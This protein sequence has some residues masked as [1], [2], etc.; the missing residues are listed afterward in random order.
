MKKLQGYGMMRLW[1]HV[2]LDVWYSST[3]FRG[4]NHINSP[5]KILRCFH[6]ILRG[7]EFMAL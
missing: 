4:H 6:R 2:V 1:D 5:F 7:W 3:R